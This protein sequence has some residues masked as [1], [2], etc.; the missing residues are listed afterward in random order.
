MAEGYL[1]NETAVFIRDCVDLIEAL[2]NMASFVLN[3]HVSGLAQHLHDIH[4][5]RQSGPAVNTPA[6]AN[7]TA[8]ESSQTTEIG[9]LSF[10]QSKI[11]AWLAGKTLSADS[12]ELPL[13]QFFMIGALSSG[14]GGTLLVILL[15]SVAGQS[16]GGESVPDRD[17]PLAHGARLK[18][19]RRFPIEFP[20][21][22]AQ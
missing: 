14:L 8:F 4:T 15:P 11:N 21:G 19:I 18:K 7:R 3:S 20:V 6:A 13:G 1:V 17:S 2:F 10:N 16:A 22:L 12:V 5:Q 9:V